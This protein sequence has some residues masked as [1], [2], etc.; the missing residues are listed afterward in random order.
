MREIDI[1]WFPIVIFTFWFLVSVASQLRTEWIG[2]RRRYDVFGLV[3]AWNFFAPRPIVT[4]YLISYRIWNEDTADEWITLDVPGRRRWTDAFFNP[5]RR[6]RKALW[7]AGHAISWNLQDQA[8]SPLD[9]AYLL[10][11][12]VV[13]KCVH[14]RGEPSGHVQFRVDCIKFSLSTNPIR[15]R[16]FLSELHSIGSGDD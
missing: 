16:W 13:T 10:L 1:G 5:R 14:C 15:L 12:G 8:V 2:S 6:K 11:L 3:P 9:P 4:D 7:T